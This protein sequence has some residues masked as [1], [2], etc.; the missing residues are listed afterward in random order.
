MTFIFGWKNAVTLL[1]VQ[2]AKKSGSWS[3]G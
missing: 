3:C 2:C 1:T